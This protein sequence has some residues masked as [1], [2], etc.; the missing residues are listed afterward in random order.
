VNIP[1]YDAT[2]TPFI[3]ADFQ[4]ANLPL[5]PNGFKYDLGTG[6]PNRGQ[7]PCELIGVTMKTEVRCR[8]FHG[9]CKIK[10]Y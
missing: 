5:F 7:I 2:D 4:L 3:V 1:A 10:Y 6:V 8:L 9:S